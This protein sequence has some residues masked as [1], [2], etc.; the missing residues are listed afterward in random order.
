MGAGFQTV[1]E[2]L[3]L[4]K[5]EDFSKGPL[6]KAEEW[7]RPSQHLDTMCSASGDVRHFVLF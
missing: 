2:C 6:S 3:G 4:Q 7:A 1:W 5:L